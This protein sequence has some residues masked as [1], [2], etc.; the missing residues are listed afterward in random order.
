MNPTDFL[1]LPLKFGGKIV[2]AEDVSPE[3]LQQAKASKRV[4]YAF[5]V[6]PVAVWLPNLIYPET[7]EEVAQ[8]A[9]W[10]PLKYELPRELEVIEWYRRTVRA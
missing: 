8:F 6:S 4:Y 5:G 7:V 1:Q 3:E 2:S 9:R 10:Y